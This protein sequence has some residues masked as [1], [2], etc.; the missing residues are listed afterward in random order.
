MGHFYCAKINCQLDPPFKC[1]SNQDEFKIHTLKCR[2]KLGLASADPIFSLAELDRLK[3][4]ANIFL[5]LLQFSRANHEIFSHIFVLKKL[6][7]SASML[8]PPGSE[9][10]VHIHREKVAHES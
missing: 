6:M 1:Q 3:P 2:F 5:N 8:V 4:L 9:I 7:Y 10:T